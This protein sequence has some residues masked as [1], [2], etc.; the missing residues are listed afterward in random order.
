MDLDALTHLPGMRT[1]RFALPGANLHSARG[2]YVAVRTP[3]APS[4][5]YAHRLLIAGPP[6]DD[7]VEVWRA[8]WLAENPDPARRPPKAFVCWEQ[9]A[10]DPSH[11]DR[12]RAAGVELEMQS[13]CHHDGALPPLPPRPRDL[14]VR[15]VRTAAEWAAVTATSERAFQWSGGFFAWTDSERRRRVARGEAIEWGAFADG[16]L[17]GHCGLIRGEGE[18]RFQDV[19]VDPA[20]HGRK[21]GAHLLASALRHHAAHH[22]GEPAWITAD[23]DSRP[24]R[25]YRALGFRPVSYT[26]EVVIEIGP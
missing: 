14:I 12:A 23:L 15:P 18:A 21:V 6:W 1:D 2:G 22:P 25:I 7:G 26:Y 8:R 11:T 16:A 20:H 17:V 9:P 10:P 13:V 3:D 19:A 24:D 5:W 4:F